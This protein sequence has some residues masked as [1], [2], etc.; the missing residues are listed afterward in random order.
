MF[1]VPAGISDEQSNIVPALRKF[2]RG[3]SFNYLSDIFYGLDYSLPS[4]FNCSG[5]LS[6]SQSLMAQCKGNET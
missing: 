4:P 3:D 2:Q 5:V 6:S 1:D